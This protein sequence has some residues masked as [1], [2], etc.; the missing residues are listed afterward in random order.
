MAKKLLILSGSIRNGSYNT[1]LARLALELALSK[2]AKTE[3]ID[4]AEYPLPLFNAD[5]EAEHGVH[6]NAIRLKAKFVQ[7]D[8]FFIASPEY[9]SSMTPLL[10]N[11]L[12]WIS[13]KHEENEA[14]LIAYA[15]K[16][17]AIS[18]AS[19]GALGAIRALVPLR[20]L[21]S[22]L[23]VNLVGRQLA[24]PKAREAFDDDS[25]LVSAFHRSMLDKIITSL[26]R[27]S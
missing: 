15:D 19:P 2:G 18:G 14:P 21:L 17:G 9:N 23:G 5:E 3:L 10:K 8:G 26:I 16:A 7:A 25:K 24:I 6:E 1:R 27:I 4:L 13:R 20:L 22:N 11:T 12:D